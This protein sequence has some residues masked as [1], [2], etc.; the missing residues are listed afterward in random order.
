MSACLT[1][2]GGG[3]VGLNLAA[4]LARG[5]EDVLLVVRRPAVAAAIETN[6]ACVSDPATGAR[7]RVGLATTTG[8]DTIAPRL[9]AGPVIL[10]TRAGDEV[11]QVYVKHESSKVERPIKELR[12]FERVAL[13]PGETKTVHLTLPA[14][15]L[16]YWDEKANR[17]TVE[18]GPVRLMIG[19]SSSDV[20]LETT[21]IVSR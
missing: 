4:R 6:G 21:V 9:R 17:F 12:G 11:V 14:E 20:K 19:G 18:D 16:A 8:L 3:A 2:I 7:W 1:L 10:C 15:S 5:G 13:Q